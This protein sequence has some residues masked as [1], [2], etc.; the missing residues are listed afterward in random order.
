MYYHTVKEFKRGKFDVVVSWGHEDTPLDML[1]D[2]TCHDIQEMA[3]KIDSGLLDYFVARVQFFYN[4]VETG[5]DY[6]GGCLY[7]DV[8]KAFE[9]GLDGYLEDMIERAEAESI[10]YVAELKENILADFGA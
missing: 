9:D 3:R 5:C 7:E 8:N 10:V 2:D 1:F 6:L 4:G